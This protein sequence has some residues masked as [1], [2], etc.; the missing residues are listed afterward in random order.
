MS[1]LSSIAIATALLGWPTLRTLPAHA[2]TVQSSGEVAATFHLEPNH[3]PR[4]GDPA[5]VWFALTARG[6]AIVPL[7]DCDCRLAIY[8]EP[9]QAGDAPIA[10]PALT[11]IAA[12]QYRDIPGASVVFPEPGRYVLELSGQPAGTAT[13]APFQFRYATTVL[14]AT[15][16]A[17]NPVAA[18]P[19]PSP[20]NPDRAALPPVDQRERRSTQQ[21]IVVLSST[22][23]AAIVALG[24][25]LRWLLSRNPAPNNS[26]PS[27][28]AVKRPPSESE[29]GQF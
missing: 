29:R 14:A 17:P 18:S 8:A 1:R 5:Q 19:T 3:N 15:G 6:G 22:A 9:R 13:F 24:L 11:A 10:E 23:I 20:A 16:S 27:N 28:S 26:V 25:G 4:A 2:H 21:V 12:E 7:A